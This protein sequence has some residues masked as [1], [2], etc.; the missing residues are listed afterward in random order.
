MDD[1]TTYE[2]ARV[3][4]YGSLQE[5]TAGCIGASGGDSTVRSGHLG[6]FIVGPEVHTSQIQCTSTP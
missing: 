2:K 6:E 4:D 3:I 1:R 5:L